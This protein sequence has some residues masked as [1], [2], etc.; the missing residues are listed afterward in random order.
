MESARVRGPAPP[1]PGA[2]HRPGA[3]GYRLHGRQAPLQ[4]AHCH[5][6]LLHSV[7]CPLKGHVPLLGFPLVLAERDLRH[8]RRMC[9]VG[10][11]K[12]SKYG[13]KNKTSLRRSPRNWGTGMGEGGSSGE[14]TGPPV[15]AGGPRGRRARELHS[16]GSMAR[17]GWG[18][19][20]ERPSSSA[21]HQQ[22]PRVFQCRHA[23]PNAATL[24]PM[25][26]R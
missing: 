26:P 14:H 9:D 17:R 25:P 18:C 8:R 2:A 22:P 23:E 15:P 13:L 21:R 1:G 20:S 10:R 24:N 19:S 12:E 11:R 5:L 7:L 4:L 6:L 16:P 3:H